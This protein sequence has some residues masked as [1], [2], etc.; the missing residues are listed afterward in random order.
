MRVKIAGQKNE[1][2]N[3]A[4]RRH[5]REPGIA[6]RRSVRLDKGYA[7][8]PHN[9]IVYRRSVKGDLIE[10]RLSARSERRRTITGR[11]RIKTSAAIRGEP[12]A[13]FPYDFRIPAEAA[14]DFIYN[15]LKSLARPTGIEPVFSP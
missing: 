14:V 9:T 11:Q 13:S 5:T 7:S 4:C 2:D 8:E 6:R 10:A 3:D 15:L 12:G 1:Q